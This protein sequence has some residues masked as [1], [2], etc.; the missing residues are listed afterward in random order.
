M[1]TFQIYAYLFSYS[2][3]SVIGQNVLGLV[4]SLV[5][6]VTRVYLKAVGLMFIARLTSFIVC[7]AYPLRV[8]G[9]LD[10]IPADFG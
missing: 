1:P 6:L 3:S 4:K 5:G 2:I 9:D 7:V 8:T 10:P